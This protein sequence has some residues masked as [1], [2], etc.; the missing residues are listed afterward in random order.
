MNDAKQAD[1]AEFP[2][3]DVYC[4]EA[5]GEPGVGITLYPGRP[6]PLWLCWDDTVELRDYLNRLV[7]AWDAKL[8]SAKD[9]RGIL[10]D[11]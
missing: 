2:G 10:N 3:L 4:L 5:A 7:E 11:R 6:G 1:T 8:P 9:V